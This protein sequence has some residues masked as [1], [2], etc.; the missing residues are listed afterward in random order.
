MRK[1]DWGLWQVIIGIIAIILTI[2]GFMI[3]T[4]SPN[5]NNTMNTNNNIIINNSP[6]TPT[7]PISYISVSS[8][9]VG[10]SVYLDGEYEGEV[11][12]ILKN[13]EPGSHLITLKLTGYNDWSQAIS[14]DAG[15]T[16]SILPTLTPDVTSTSISDVTPTSTSDV[17]P[18]STSDVT[19]TSTS[20][21]TPTSTSDVTPTST[22]GVVTPPQNVVTPAPVDISPYL[23]WNFITSKDNFYV[24]VPEG[25]SFVSVTINIHNNGDDPISTDSSCWKFI[26]DGVSYSCESVTSAFDT[27]N[28]Y[29]VKSGESLTFIKNYLVK[30]VPTTGSLQYIQPTYYT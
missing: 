23:N 11:P 12:Q 15:K 21:V 17:T 24:D 26:F 28:Q 18:T 27:P 5:H 22:S 8:S 20:D 16:V 6:S 4:E 25:Y 30:G 3:H 14:V 29:E 9:P 1:P 10:S 7:T 2:A 13:I 19:P